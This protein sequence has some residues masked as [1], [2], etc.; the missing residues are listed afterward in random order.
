M[1]LVT[2]AEMK[3]YLGITG[4]DDDAFLTEQIELISD[5]IEAYCRRKFAQASY[6]QTWYTDDF[7]Y[8]N[9]REILP[10]HFPI[11]SV[12]TLKVDGVTADS[13]EYRIHKP[14]G[15]IKLLSD[16]DH[17]WDELELTFSAG[18]ATIPTIVKSVVYQLVE[19]RYNKKK[20]GVSLN[21]GSD[22]QRVSIPGTISIDFDYSLQTNERSSAFGQI[23]G[24]TLNVLDNYR[25]ERAFTHI[26][27]LDFVT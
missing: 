18:F 19:E 27:E 21:F 11:I 8:R 26:K 4:N 22:V 17:S 1:G 24:N 14:T 13:E 9:P 20:S 23:L 2:L 6:V 5:T 15:I 10:F 3:T 12:T 7:N 16:F 25:S